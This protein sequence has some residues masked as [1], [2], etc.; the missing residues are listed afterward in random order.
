MV[1]LFKDRSPAAIFW[2][3][4]LSIIVHSHFFVDA[5]V[6][7]ASNEDGLL[8]TFL[9]DYIL[10][11]D[12]GF[13][14]F[15]YHAFVIIQALRLN[16]LFTDHRMYSKIN[17]LPAM[18]YILLTGVFTEWSSL[19]PALIINTVLIW[20]FAKTIRL[21]SNPNPKALLFNI[22]IL[23]AV[24]IILYHPS[25]LLIPVAFFALMVLRPFIVT[26]W[27]VLIMGV[28]FPYYLLASYLYLTDRL[29]SIKNYIP[30]WQFN[31][32]N[33]QNRIVFFITIAVIVIVLLM[34]LFYWQQENRRLLI[35]VRKNWVVLLA[36]FFVLLPLP[37]IHKNAGIES[38]ILCIVPASPIIAK[39]FLAPKKNTIPA[40]MFWALISLAI[41]KNWQIIH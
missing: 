15:I 5:P 39:G 4:M 34:G 7:Y 6:V 25:V 16:H 18:V 11:L 9:N 20:F 8:S 13:I 38:F 37:F 41:L 30:L 14:V 17:Y 22:G 33:I 1:A 21:Y 31:L 40:L 26:E 28:I 23:T 10:P 29:Q 35:Q 24:S 32:P 3:I 36:M 2:L 27:I 19:N 12:P